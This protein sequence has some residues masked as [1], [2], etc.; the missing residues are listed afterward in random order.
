MS[1]IEKLDY[2]SG[3]VSKRIINGIYS[4]GTY[5][6]VE[7]PSYEPQYVMAISRNEENGNNNLGVCYFDV[8]TF[9]LY[10][11]SFT[12][13]S[14]CNTLRTIITKIRPLEIIYDP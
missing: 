9:K 14:I 8:S 7:R 5:N 4:K 10:L 1:L 12:D 11:G 2:K 6:N 13:N 3:N